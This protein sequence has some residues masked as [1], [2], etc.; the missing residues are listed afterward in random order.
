MV[1]LAELPRP[2]AS[3]RSLDDAPTKPSSLRYPSPKLTMLDVLW[4]YLVAGMGFTTGV[5]ETTMTTDGTPLL[6]ETMPFAVLNVIF[7]AA[8][9]LIIRYRR[10][11]PMLVFLVTMLASIFPS[12]ALTAIWAFVSLCTRR[13]LFEIV[14][15]GS[16]FFGTTMLAIWISQRPAVVELQGAPPWFEFWTTLAAAAL[17]VIVPAAFG[18][19]IG[20]RR[21]LRA[22]LMEQA[23]GA[24]RTQELAVLRGQADERARIAQE[25]Q[26]VL[27]DRLEQI[28]RDS[29]L[30]LDPDR[31]EEEFARTASEIQA[32]AHAS[33]QDLRAVLGVL[34]SS[35]APGA[36]PEK[37]QPGMADIDELV[38]SALAAGE[39]IEFTTDLSDPEALRGPVGRHAYRIVQ[40]GLMNAR[41]HAPGAPVGVTL[42]GAPAEGLTIVISNPVVGPVGFRPAPGVG[43][44]GLE[45]RAR[46]VGGSLTHRITPSGYFELRV[47]LP[48]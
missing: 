13:R 11:H 9:L 8:A 16:L 17:I 29:R 19:Y 26:Q 24:E 40:E 38:S 41:T 12:V 47:W 18:A 45:E 21:D 10:R 32:T 28:G 37:P 48:W 14:G 1:N 27:A 23:D 3:A 42:A 15:A 44:M 34:R 39:R 6:M 46:I 31:S 33:L 35:Q 30:L 22:S 36:L 5:L 7:G 4:R 20:A 2:D 25:M 43:L